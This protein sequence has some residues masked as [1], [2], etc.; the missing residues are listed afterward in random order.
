[1]TT[2]TA[3][4]PEGKRRLFGLLGPKR[5]RILVNGKPIRARGLQ[6]V[7]HG[8]V[9]GLLGVCLFAGLY[10]A[11]IQVPWHIWLHIGSFQ[12]RTATSS[13]K[14]WWD[15]GMGFIHSGDW[16]LYRHA[17]RNDGEP[18]AFA[19]FASMIAAPPKYW[20]KRV[21]IVRLIATPPLLLVATMALIVAGTYAIIH[22]APS[23]WSYSTLSIILGAAIGVAMRPLWKPIGATLQGF[24]VDRSIDVARGKGH[25]PLWERTPLGPPT[26]RERYSEMKAHDTDTETRS[27]AN[28]AA[29]ITFLVVAFVLIVLGAL[30]KFGFAHG[31]HLPYL[32][33]AAH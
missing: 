30:A 11:V 6:Q 23:N 19:L 32:Y 18:A 28:R 25:D 17:I 7:I 4:P 21:G 1:V 5:E 12:W 2:I 20:G 31:L 27:P 26:L 33:P 24:L 9:I 10:E 14:S 16:K 29:V 13:I 22:W 15:G 3:L 8:S